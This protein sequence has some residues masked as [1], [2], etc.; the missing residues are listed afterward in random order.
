M[1]KI[2]NRSASSAEPHVGDRRPFS[3]LWFDWKEY[4]TSY[5]VSWS[6]IAL[7]NGFLLLIVGRSP[8]H[9][10]YDEGWYL[11]T[12]RLMRHFGLSIAFIKEL[13]GPAGPTFTIV[14]AFVQ[15]ILGIKFPLL[16]LT[17][18]LLLAISAVLLFRTLVTQ[19]EAIGAGRRLAGLPAGMFT[20]L[21]TVGVSAGMT[22]TEMPAVFFVA[23]FLFALTKSLLTTSARRYLLAILA[24]IAFAVAIL[25]RQNY[26]VILPC[27]PVLVAGHDIIG[28]RPKRLVLILVLSAALLMVTPIFVTW[29]GLVP[30]A[31]AFVGRGISP[32][33][34]ILS[35]GYT[36]IIAAL[37]APKLYFPL[38]SASRSMLVLLLAAVAFDLFGTAGLSPM[39][40]VMVAVEPMS[41]AI[42]GAIDVAVGGILCLAAMAFLVA[43]VGH[44]WT[45]W[46]DRLIRF[47][48]VVLSLGMLSNAAITSQ[49][50]SRYVVVFLPFLVVALSPYV[51]PTW[52]LPVRISACA[53]L[54]L[55]SLLS[56]FYG[57]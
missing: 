16:R 25:G 54:G 37:F 2:T 36:G 55:T 40:S 31:T 11:D 18:V 49:F 15:N 38:S 45:Y 26:L 42:S 28:D 35:A 8:D 3:T 22:L 19:A 47:C 17:N 46:D 7:A 39:R 44:L 57:A 29:H 10:V 12:I 5:L 56:Y 6:I 9:A 51:R 13:P 1:L 33:H 50:S 4:D 23:L 27:L 53:L 41:G 48:S 14:F 52:N 21:P 20:V 30:P 32:W 43:M 24:G 34:A